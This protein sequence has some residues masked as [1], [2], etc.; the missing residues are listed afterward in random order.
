MMNAHTQ[1]LHPAGAHAPSFR[2]EDG[3]YGQCTNGAMHVVVDNP[4]TR[5]VV[6]GW[7]VLSGYKRVYTT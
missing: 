5:P 6:L 1:A 4:S 2:N 7:C 3:T